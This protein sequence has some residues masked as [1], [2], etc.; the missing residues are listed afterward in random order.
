MGRRSFPQLCKGSILEKN[1][2]LCQMLLY[3]EYG[4]NFKITIGSGNWIRELVTLARTIS[5]HSWGETLVGFERMVEIKWDSKHREC[6]YLRNFAL[7][8]CSEMLQRDAAEK[9]GSS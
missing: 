3:I 2:H 1:A 6:K 7:K 9:P 4:E 5:V 8:G